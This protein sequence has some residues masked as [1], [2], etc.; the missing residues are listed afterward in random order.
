MP[1]A[2]ITPVVAVLIE[3]VKEQ[4]QVFKK[5]NTK[6]AEIRT[7]IDRLEIRLIHQGILP[8]FPLNRD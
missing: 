6:L 3:T 7:K 1:N 8:L 2:S 4:Q 5:Q